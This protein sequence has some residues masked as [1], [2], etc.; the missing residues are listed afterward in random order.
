[1]KKPYI[2]IHEKITTAMVIVCKKLCLLYLKLNNAVFHWCLYDNNKIEHYMAAWRYRSYI[3]A[4]LQQVMM[5]SGLC[6]LQYGWNY[7][8]HCFYVT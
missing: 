6:Q 4:I 2:S 8:D 1:M 7:F 3:I 5:S